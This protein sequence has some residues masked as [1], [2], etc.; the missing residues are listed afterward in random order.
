[1]NIRNLSKLG[2]AKTL[3]FV[4]LMRLW[5]LNNALWISVSLN[6]LVFRNIILPHFNLQKFLL[7]VVK[8][9]I[10]IKKRVIIH[11]IRVTFIQLLLINRYFSLFQILIMLKLNK[12][13]FFFFIII[14]IVIITW[15]QFTYIKVAWFKWFFL[16]NYMFDFIFIWSYLIFSLFFESILQYKLRKLMMWQRLTRKLS[17]L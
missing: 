12:I 4:D 11:M 3:I 17:L 15:S 13:W 10:F 8:I 7:R 14:K 6:Y 5:R 1:M 2:C 9:N 16:I